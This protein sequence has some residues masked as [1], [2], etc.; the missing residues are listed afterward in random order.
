MEGDQIGTCARKE[1]PTLLK[2]GS[3]HKECHCWTPLEFIGLL[4]PTGWR[5]GG[6]GEAV[7]STPLPKGETAHKAL[8]I[9]EGLGKKIPKL[10]IPGDF[11]P[12]KLTQAH[13][14]NNRFS[15]SEPGSSS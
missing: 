14:E 9:F 1:R 11:S 8:E 10:L 13:K 2:L 15:D 6:E 12:N 5:A 4:A 3:V 7:R